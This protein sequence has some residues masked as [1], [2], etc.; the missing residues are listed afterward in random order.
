M[1]EFKKIITVVFLF[2]ICFMCIGCS[3][4]EKEVSL[5]QKE[6]LQYDDLELDNADIVQDSNEKEINQLLQNGTGVVFIGKATDKLSRKAISILLSASD[7]TDLKKIYYLDDYQS[8]DGLEEIEN[9]KIP[10]VLFVLDGKIEKYHVGTVEDK[11]DL[12]E[13]QT[14]EL[15]NIYLDGIHVVLQD[16][17][18]ESC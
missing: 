13:D 11:V 7:N 16:T 15:Y 18:D 12:D 8:I 1:E 4:E 17:C 3:K 9:I 14:L 5:F 2:F 6:F 10:I